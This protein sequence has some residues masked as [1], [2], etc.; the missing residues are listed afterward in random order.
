MC[1]LG[2]A[3]EETTRLLRGLSARRRLLPSSARWSEKAAHL[4]PAA[5]AESV[6]QSLGPLDSPQLERA[7]KAISSGAA[8][9]C[10]LSNTSD[11]IKQSARLALTT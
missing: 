8:A 9:T 10:F 6:F 4:G 1:S 7:S 11:N 2:R 3:L 5:R